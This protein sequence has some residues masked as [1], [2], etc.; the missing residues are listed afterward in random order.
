MRLLS[1]LGTALLVGIAWALSTN[2]KAIDWRI[3][4]WGI[5]LQLVFALLVLKTMPGRLFFAGVNDAFVD[6]LGFSR[7]GARFLFG[8]L[9]DTNVPVGMPQGAPAS[10]A[11]IPPGGITAWARTGAFFAFGVLPS[12]IFFAALMALLY[13][14]RLLQWVVRA[15]AWGMR[16]TMRTSGA[17]TLAASANIFVGQTEAPLMVKPYIAAMTRSELNCLMAAGFANTAGG[18]L[19]AYVGLLSPLFPE[20]GGHLIAATIMSA[21]AALAFSK[22][23]VPETE[24]PATLDEAGA[25]VGSEDA[26]AIGA[27][28]RGAGEGLVLALNVGAMLMAFIALIALANGIVGW[29]GGLAGLA[30]LTLQRLLGWALAPLAFAMGVPAGEAVQV[31][32]LLGVKTVVNEF[33]AYLQLSDALQ[34]RPALSPRSA[35]IAT[36]ALSG[37]ANFASIAVQIGG[38]GSMAPERRQDLARLGLRAMVAGS[39][40]SFQTA[41]IAGMLV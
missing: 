12:I 14:L 39:L 20:I 23:M 16:R 36:Y 9:V 17:E 30:N 5:G 18:V 2:R 33:V 38:I 15:F 13:H 19:V 41:T 40:A 7:E 31:G 24:R 21:P 1:L 6:L 29:L 35:V 8:N 4:A 37:F 11:P 27:A 26:N 22:L 32:S 10:G 34:A 25:P 3:V 28:A